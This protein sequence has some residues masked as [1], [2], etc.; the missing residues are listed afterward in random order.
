VGKLNM[1]FQKGHTINIGKQCHKKI[2]KFY[3]NQFIEMVL[4]VKT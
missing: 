3:G 4:N 2:C 1:P